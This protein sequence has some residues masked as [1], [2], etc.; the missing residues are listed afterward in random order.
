MP[1]L[2]PDDI[3]E[4]TEC[5]SLFI[6]NS[7]AWL[8]IVSG[9]IDPLTK[10]YNWEE[11]GTLT[12]AECAERMLEMLNEYYTVG[13]SDCLL[14]D[15]ERVIRLSFEGHFEELSGGAWVTPTGDYEVPP[16]EERTGGTPEDQMC[17]AAA[18]AENVLATL[19]EQVTDDFEEHLST[20]EALLALGVGIGIAIAPP[21][22]LLAG[23]VL[24]LGLLAF[25][26]F[27]AFMEFLT[28]DV[29]SVEFSDALRCMLYNCASN[30][31]GVVTFDI[32]CVWAQLRD[33]SNPFDLSGNEQRLLGQV[34]YLLS[35]IGVDGL[36][37]AGATTA[38]E[39]AD[40]SDCAEDLCPDLP[41]E[42]WDLQEIPNFY[43]AS[44]PAGYTVTDQNFGAVAQL[45]LYKD[46]YTKAGIEFDPMCVKRV[47][48][49][50]NTSNFA[51]TKLE[52]RL[53]GVTLFESGFEGG[54][55]EHIYN[56][57]ENTYCDEIRLQ[58]SAGTANGQC[59]WT[60]CEIAHLPPL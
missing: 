46:D 7:S 12:P 48:W 26:E 43:T 18:N 50:Q 58:Q 8:A 2:T 9:A 19:Y 10:E 36:N 35:I 29:W 20:A 59:Y 4:G 5:R 41:I 11:F 17:L 49:N 28:D 6:P 14:P 30:D 56:L 60:S 38:I 37:L 15:G 32:D 55:G 40:C 31:E 16:V 57:S 39:T 34:G 52:F 53:G 51:G 3:P 33:D 13:C 22:G 1:W 42:D 21:L 27:F 23:A 44:I 54:N 45:Y 47:R 24:A 25:G